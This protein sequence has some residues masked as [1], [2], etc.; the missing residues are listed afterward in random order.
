MAQARLKT[1]LLCGEGIII[2]DCY[3]YLNRLRLSILLND[4]FV[5][6]KNPVDCM[7]IFQTI[8]KEKRAYLK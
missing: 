2:F 5:I 4:S 7:F 6:Y 3:S 8:M 1:G